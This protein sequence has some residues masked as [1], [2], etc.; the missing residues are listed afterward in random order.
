MNHA[1]EAQNQGLGLAR[2]AARARQHKAEKFNS[3]MHHVTPQLLETCIKQMDKGTATGIDGLSRD[4]VLNNL[5]W[6]SR[7]ALQEAHKGT[8]TAKPVRQVLIPKPDGRQRPLGVPTVFE[9][10]FQHAV[11]KVLESIF[12]Q[13]F[14][15]VSFGFRPGLGCHH[16]LASLEKGLHQD[17]SKH[18]LE[19]DIRDFFGSLDHQWLRK[20]LRHRIGDERILKLIDTWLE[21]GVMT[22]EGLVE[23]T[24]G[25][26]QGGGISPLLANIYLHYVLDL[27]FEKIIKSRL[28]GRSQLVRFADDFVILFEN[29]QDRD[30]FL[31]VL[32]E[33][34]RQF[35]LEIA[36]NKTHKT[37]VVLS[38]Q[39]SKHKRRAI[40]FLGF[41]IHRAK[42]RYGKG[43]KFVFRTESKRF[44]K[45]K[46]NIKAELK[47]IQ[48]HPLKEQGKVLNSLLRGHYNYFGLPGN[49]G[50][51]SELSYWVTLA[52]RRSLSRRSQR[53]KQTWAEF[54]QTLNQLKIAKPRL[55]ITY[56]TLGTYV[57]L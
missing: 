17:G 31:P 8:Y 7:H 56:N 55:R 1:V 42:T 26:V 30:D 49:S 47:K 2:I 36:E 21:A 5:D 28:A 13:D 54:T 14:L 25:V 39:D 48:H 10:G 40:K 50:K 23:S 20:F 29:E 11:A 52:F 53:G 38:S 32:T 37:D 12:E 6:I 43:Y 33:R 35:N 27:W 19:V 44:T 22:Q 51:L 45:V 34:F 18:A 41:V 46:A 4:A 15:A 16:A 9:R 24:T 3:L 57:R